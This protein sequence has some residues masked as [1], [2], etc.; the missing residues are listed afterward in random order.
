MY[1]RQEWWIFFW[2]KSEEKSESGRKETVERSLW[3]KRAR[4]SI[5]DK[6]NNPWEWWIGNSLHVFSLLPSQL[7]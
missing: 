7:K 6:C 4:S 3:M 1:G 2:S 5:C